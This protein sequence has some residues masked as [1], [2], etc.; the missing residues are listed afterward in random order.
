MTQYD[1]QLLS[2]KQCDYTF[3]WTPHQ[4]PD[5]ENKISRSHYKV[6]SKLIEICW[7]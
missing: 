2:A 5:H 1:F 3:T 6:L 7:G 4:G